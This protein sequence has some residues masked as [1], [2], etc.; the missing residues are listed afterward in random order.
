M[1]TVLT[2]FSQLSNHDVPVVLLNTPFKSWKSSNW[3]FALLANHIPIVTSKKSRNNVFK[4]YAVDKPFSIIP[5]YKENKK[6]K[7]KKLSGKEFFRLLIDSNKDHYM[8]ASGDIDLLQMNNVFTSDSLEQVT[9]GDFEPGQVNF[10]FGSENVT[11]YTHYDTSHNLHTV[12]RGHKKF[13]L[14][15]PSAYKYLK[16]Y[17]SLHTFYR[18]TQ[19]DIL[20]LTQSEF[21]ELLF[22][23]SFLEVVLERH[24]TLYIPPYWFHCVVTVEPSISLN[25]WSQSDMFLSMEDIY[26]LPI[27]FEETW[28]QVKLLKVLQYFVILILRDAL[29]HFNNSSHFVNDAVLKHY[30]QIFERLSDTKRDEML[31]LVKDFCLESHIT[32]ILDSSSLQYVTDGAEKISKLFRSMFPLSVREINVANYLEHL[33]WRILGSDNVVLVP[34]YYEKCFI[35]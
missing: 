29:P 31:L 22:Q 18:Q 10:W 7:T 24:E 5:E 34:F 19:V 32:T 16:L 6:Y 25:V 11:A 17:P 35:L 28:D 12:I 23:T 27:P 14:L 15:P 20:N 30:Y 3:T 2:Y 8:Y 1:Y 33:A 9:F 21:R 4:Y 26:S 13:L